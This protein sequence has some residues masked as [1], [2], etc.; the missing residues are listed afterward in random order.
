LAGVRHTPYT[1]RLFRGPLE[2]SRACGAARSQRSEGALTSASGRRSLRGRTRGNRRS[3]LWSRNVVRG[4]TQASTP[5][6][7]SEASG[8]AAPSS[9]IWHGCRWPQ[10][11]RARDG[12]AFRARARVGR[13]ATRHVGPR[14]A[15][16][17]TFACGGT[18]RCPSEG[19]IKLG[20][21]HATRRSRA[22]PPCR[23]A[24]D[25]RGSALDSSSTPAQD[26]R[27][28]SRAQGNAD[29]RSAD[30]TSGARRH[31]DGT[32][33]HGARPRTGRR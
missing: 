15:P 28:A 24:A 4:R 5:T 31:A 8:G 20:D 6:G 26:A 13:D 23:V 25:D 18:T 21:G 11:P 19:A 32:G 9:K 2:C 30:A 12:R 3:P 27:V 29:S 14:R 10:G 1:T 16:Q 7:R 33:A 22:C 17:P